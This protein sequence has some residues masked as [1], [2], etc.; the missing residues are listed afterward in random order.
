MS[1]EEQ[2][3]ELA[4]REARAR[5]M[6]G[7]E[8]LARRTEQGMLNARSRL[9][10]LLDRDSFR[11]V[12]LLAQSAIRADRDT[13]PADGK[14][15]GFGRVEGRDIA[16]VSNDLTV[17]G[18]SSS[19][20]NAKKI[21]YIKSTAIRSGMPVVFLG[22]SSGA[23]IPDTMGAESMSQGGADPQQYCRRRE[24]PWAS[25]V[26]GPCFGSSTWYSCLSDFLVMRKGATLAVSSARVTTLA[27][28]E[29]V[30]PEELGGWRLHSEVTGLADAVADSD[31]EALELVR[32][33]LSYL[34]S[35]AGEAPP[36]QSAE[37]WRAPNGD[38][39]LALVPPERARVYDIR[40][41]IRAVADEGSVFPLKERFGKA[42]VTSLARMEG[43]SVGFLATNP[44]IRGGAMDPDACRKASDFLVM[45]DSFNIPVILLVDTPGFLV[46]VSGERKAAPAHIMNMMHALQL[47]SV[48][49][50]SVILRKSYGQAFLNMG[51]G[52]NSDEI[53]AWTSAEVS[54]MDPGVGASVVHGLK[55][56]EDPEAFDAAAAAL[57]KDTSAYDM[58]SVFG[59]QSV[60]DPRDTRAFLVAALATHRRRLSNGIGRHE[61]ANWPT[62]F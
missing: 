12:G 35:H 25:A 37:E 43:Q 48:P 26:L 17:K 40:K 29:T 34:P 27:I 24:T 18:A 45:C 13:T 31:E 23:R 5:A 54:F 42:V 57:R 3:E 53:A 36:V 10:A 58:A 61:M 44:M 59:V 1:Y 30:D 22:E 6:G 7:E 51:G 21:A 14:V 28:G 49:K 52:R 55:R 50:V 41:I 2:L 60:I 62:Y 9:D 8:K 4:R 39:I 11:E 20:T 33:F 16:V 46:G 38:D 56:D 32:R 15:S 19:A 47:V